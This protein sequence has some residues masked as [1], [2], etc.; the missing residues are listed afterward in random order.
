MPSRTARLSLPVLAAC[1]VAVAAPAAVSAAPGTGVA[2]FGVGGKGKAAK[3]LTAAGV[4]RIPV[5]PARKATGGRIALPVRGIA[6]GGSSATVGLR[7]GIAFRAG[8]RTVRLQSTRIVLRGKRARISAKVGKA[9]RTFFTATLPSGRAKLDRAALTATFSRGTLRLTRAGAKL[10]RSKL[11]VSG[12]VAGPLGGLAVSARRA[13]DGNPRSGELGPEPP[14]KARPASAVDVSGIT[15]DW[16]P[17]DS[18]VRYLSSGVGAKDGSH[19]TGGAAKLPAQLTP[20]HP[21]SDAPYSGSG[22]FDYGF[23]FAPRSGWYDPAT[24]AAALYGQGSVRF[25]WASHQIDLAAADPE[26]EIDGAASRAIFAFTG[27]G[28]TAFSDERSDLVALDVA[29]RPTTSGTTR[30][31]TAMRGRLTANGQSAFAGFY[32]PPGDGFGCLS[33]SFTTP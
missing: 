9:R 27:K 6:V 20:T 14:V 8:T 33:I 13:D 23:R 21:C 12:V 16:Y 5:K 22:S 32:P 25:V 7:G 2:T 18:W 15:I 17:R 19:A 1:V 26:I 11:R 3:A 28:G 10:L 31:Y 29:G 30:T 4:K 24:G